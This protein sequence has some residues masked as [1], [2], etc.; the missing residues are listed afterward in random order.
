MSSAEKF[1][2]AIERF[3]NAL[4]NCGFLIKGG[5]DARADWKALAADLGEAFFDEV[6]QAGIAPEL[7]AEPPRKRLN[8]DGTAEWSDKPKPLVNVEQLFIKGVCAVRANLV[9]GN[10]IELND[11]DQRLIGESYAVLELAATRSGRLNVFF[12]SRS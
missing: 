2:I 5:G 1:R 9:H 10:K 7:I 4:Q 11:R 3:D 8:R 12:S 6:N